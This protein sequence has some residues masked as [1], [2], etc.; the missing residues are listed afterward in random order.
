MGKRYFFV[1]YVKII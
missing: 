1:M